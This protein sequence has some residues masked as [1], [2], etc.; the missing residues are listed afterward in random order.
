MTFLGREDEASGIARAIGNRPRS[1][2]WRGEQRSCS[3]FQEGI[4]LAYGKLKLR[5][6]GPGEELEHP[7]SSFVWDL[8]GIRPLYGEGWRWGVCS[9]C[10]FGGK[11]SNGSVS[12]TTRNSSTRSPTS[13]SVTGDL[14]GRQAANAA[15][16]RR[17]QLPPHGPVWVL[18]LGP[19]LWRM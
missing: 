11:G 2:L 14:R 18:R 15:D 19:S 6:S 13:P 12:F 9:A 1:R 7:C 4:W 17:S 3:G 5:P 16:L 10:C 8:A